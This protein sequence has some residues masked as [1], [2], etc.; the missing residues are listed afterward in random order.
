MAERIFGHIP[1]VP[2]GSVFQSRKALA[3]A[4]VHRP[5]QAG[6]SGSGAEGS[7]SIVV[8]GGYEDDVAL[9]TEIVYTGQGGRDPNTRQA[10]LKP[11]AKTWKSRLSREPILRSSSKMWKHSVYTHQFSTDR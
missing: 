9:G 8:S 1:D 6:I 5:L 2:V 7:D 3:E 4:G 11:A 10:G